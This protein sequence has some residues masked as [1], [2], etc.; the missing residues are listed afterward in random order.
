MKMGREPRERFRH[1]NPHVII[2]SGQEFLAMATKNFV[3]TVT[4]HDEK[5]PKNPSIPELA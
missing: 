1:Q 5:T 2:S 3:T 4:P